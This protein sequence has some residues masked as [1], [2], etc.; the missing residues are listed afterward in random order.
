MN[1]Y[2]YTILVN[3]SDGF[4]DCWHPFFTLFH[5]YWPNCDVPI[6]L[7]TEHK[8]FNFYPLNIKAS[9][10]NA[11]NERRLTW[12]ECLIE[13]IKKIESPFI[14]YFQ[15]DYF[16][17]SMVNVSQIDDFAAMMMSDDK[18]KF[19]GLTHFGNY[20]PF[21]DYSG[22]K[23]LKIVSQGSKYRISTQA[24][25]WRKETLLSYLCEDENGWM[26]EIFGTQRAKKRKD[27]FLTANREIYNEFNPIIFYQITGIVKGKWIL[28]MPLLFEKEGLEMDFLKRGFYTPKN[29]VFRKFETA[30][31]LLKKFPKLLKLILFNN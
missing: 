31:A 6:L 23:R 20:P 26:F 13:A 9:K 5:K 27:L 29:I 21:L 17:E 18:I 22:D 30:A 3:T 15:E 1:K 4:E 11:G 14:L 12:S 19:I 25:L 8:D 7:N 10:V 24:G 2:L 28:S 16:L